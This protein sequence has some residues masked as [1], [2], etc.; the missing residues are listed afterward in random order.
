VLSVGGG[1]PERSV[2][3]NLIRAVELARERHAS[4]FGIVAATEASL[5]VADICVLIP[6]IYPAHL[7]AHTEGL[8]A[9]VWHLLVSHPTLQVAKAKWESVT[10]SST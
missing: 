2:S 4:V 1:D 5:E 9:V 8:C 7:T 6:P 3:V 10:Q